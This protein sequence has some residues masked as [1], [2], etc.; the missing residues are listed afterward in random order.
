MGLRCPGI[1]EEDL[2]FGKDVLL[3]LS[4][5]AKFAF[6]CA[7][8]LDESTGK[9]LFQASMIKEVNGLRIG[10][11]SVLG[12][13]LFTLPDDPRKKGLTLRNPTKSSAN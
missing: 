5:K 1:G 7:N 6:L 4:K 13:D 12:P 11:F 2:T 3:D 8:L 9:R 10:L